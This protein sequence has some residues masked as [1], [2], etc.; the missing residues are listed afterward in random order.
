VEQALIREL[1]VQGRQILAAVEAVEL[2][3]PTA[4]GLA[5]QVL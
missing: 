2:P 4:V 3:V 5:V 1:V